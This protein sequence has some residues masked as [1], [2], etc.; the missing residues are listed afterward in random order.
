[1]V[2]EFGKNHIAVIFDFAQ[3]DV[4]GAFRQAPEKVQG[5]ECE[6]WGNPTWLY[7]GITSPTTSQELATAMCNFF[8]DRSMVANSAPLPIE[9]MEAAETMLAARYADNSTVVGIDMFNEP[10][11]TSS[12]GTTAQEG[13]LLTS[14]YTKMGQAI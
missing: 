3:V 4:S 9:A 2:S 8:N 10:W 5:G 13:A 6:G 7:P 14:F 12:C 1:M 11:F